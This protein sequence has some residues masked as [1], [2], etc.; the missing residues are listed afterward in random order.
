MCRRSTIE[1]AT[2]TISR[3][4]IVST[5]E[6]TVN[7]IIMQFISEVHLMNNMFCV[8]VKRSPTLLHLIV[9]MKPQMSPAQSGLLMN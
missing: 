2:P 1:R 5:I 9:K 6:L 3:K 8:Q 7:G 4:K